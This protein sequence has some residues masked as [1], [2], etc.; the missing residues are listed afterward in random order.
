MVPRAALAR[1]DLESG[2]F[3][4]VRDDRPDHPGTVSVVLGVVGGGHLGIRS[5]TG[6]LERDV[7]LYPAGTNPAVLRP[8]RAL[9]PPVFIPVRGPNEEIVARPDRPDG[10]ERS[11]A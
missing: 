9:E 3:R 6:F 1:H 4:L 7:A 8:Q 10:D 2:S 11:Q 5:R